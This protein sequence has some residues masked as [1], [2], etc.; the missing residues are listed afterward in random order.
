MKTTTD[1]GHEVGDHRSTTPSM[2]VS[3]DL[4]KGVI[5][6]ITGKRFAGM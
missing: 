1:R 3:E 2:I 6:V 5:D 4:L